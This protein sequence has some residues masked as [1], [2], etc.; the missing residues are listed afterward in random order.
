MLSSQQ[1]ASFNDEGFLVLPKLLDTD[2]LATLRA[3]SYAYIDGYDFDNNKAVFST[4]DRDAGRDELF[5]RSAETVE[6]FLEEHA[7]NSVGE[8][9]K[10]KHESV[11]KLGHALHDHIPA[12]TEFCRRPEFGEILRAIGY[13]NPVLWQTMVIFKQPRIGGEV[14]WHQD[15]SYLIS[16]PAS[17]TGIW[18]AMEDATRENGCLWVQPKQHRQPVW[19]RYEVDWQQRSGVLSALR[20]VP[21]PVEPRPLEVE[22]GSVVLFSDHMP[23]Y[24]AANTSSKSRLACTLHVGEQGAEWSEKNWLQRP[25]LGH[26]LL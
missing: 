12:F 1:V 13:Q 11:N 25:E 14:R 17:V 18:I 7:V 15:A 26:F 21:A 5:F 2:C 8:I 20:A 6:C 22:A 19:E 4:T 16:D 3:A 24:S 10:P 9:T 23:H